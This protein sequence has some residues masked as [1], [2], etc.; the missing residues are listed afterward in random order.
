MADDAKPMWHLAK[1]DQK[2][3][4][5]EPQQLAQMGL[6]GH[7]TSDMK[8]WKSGMPDWQPASNVK[9]L[10]VTP[11]LEEPP[12]LAA[13]RR[14][15]T[16]ASQ[17]TVPPTV[18]TGH[19]TIEKTSKAIKA[20]LLISLGVLV[21]GLIFIAAG[22]AVVRSIPSAEAMELLTV[23]QQ[24]AIYNSRAGWD[25]MLFSAG[26]MAALIGSVGVI[27]NRLRAWWEH[28]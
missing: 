6:D 22:V 12:P 17:A 27:V 15:T 24:Q 7:V 4:V 16:A 25:I 10:R 19:V 23:A 8:V 11:A 21:M 26:V 20:E 3:G 13:E 14:A 1:G 5:F 28:G 2:I 18:V 9:G